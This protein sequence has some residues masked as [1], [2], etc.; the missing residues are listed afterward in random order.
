MQLIFFV[1]KVAFVAVTA[2]AAA[3]IIIVAWPILR[4]FR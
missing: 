1:I 2:V 3:P 4:V